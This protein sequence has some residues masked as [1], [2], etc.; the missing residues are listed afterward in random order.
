MNE[1]NEKQKS[2][3]E[4]LHK[5]YK[6][7]TV[8]RTQI[9]ESVKKGEISNPSWLKSD[10]YKVGRGVYKLPLS[11]DEVVTDNDEVETEQSK[12]QAAYVA[13]SYTHLTLPTSV[14]V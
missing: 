4:I 9:N 1:L 7:D 8:T 13:V 5:K 11:A 6:S 12:S 2:V 10:K 3:V 14:T